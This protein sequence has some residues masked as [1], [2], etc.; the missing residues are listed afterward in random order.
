[1]KIYHLRLILSIALI[2]GATML[3]A[4]NDPLGGRDT[5]VLE[6]ERIEDVIDSEK[7][8]LKPPAQQ[9]QPPSL[10]DLEYLSR[11]FYVQ[12]VFKPRPPHLKPLEAER[13]PPL[14]N[15]MIR[16]GLGRYLTPLAQVYLNN[17]EDRYSNYGLNFTHF[18]SHSDE[19]SLREFREDYG[20]VYGSYQT[21]YN[22]F[23]GHVHLYNTGYF[24]YADPFAADTAATDGQI[25]DSLRMNFTR[26]ELAGNIQSLEDSEIPYYYDVGG[27]IRYYGGK[28]ENS[29]F[30][31]SLNPT[32]GISMTD[33]ISLNLNT[34]FTYIRG[35]I[36]GEKQNRTF[37]GLE[38]FLRFE[39]ETFSLKAGVQFNSFRNSVDT[40]GSQTVFGPAVEASFALIPESLDIIGGVSSGMKNNH[41]YDMIYENRFLDDDIDILPTIEKLHAYG[42]IRGNFSQLFDFT[43]K[44]YYKRW[45]NALMYTS[46]P[47]TG[48]FQATYDSLTTVVGVYAEV[49]TQFS[50]SLRGG[51]ALNINNFTTDSEEKF[52]HVAPLQLD[53]HATYTWNDQLSVNSELS[54]FGSTPMTLGET[55][56]VI[57]R[58]TFLLWNLGADYQITERFSVF[59]KLHNILNSKYQRWHNYRERPIDFMG[60][61]TII[62]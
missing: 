8:F 50:E 43:G 17:G 52:F 5:L 39:N 15:N 31:V 9:I 58:E 25:E 28:T 2:A 37:F 1:M 46:R 41:Y 45:E 13:R 16:L 27:A 44:V 26:V 62:F 47:G 23:G 51:A 48:Q 56:E 7:P 53:V 35:N 14:F 57:R 21:D 10:R 49:N 12:T 42:G 19:I 4:Q 38:P 36:V 11:D 18:S 40:T 34:D 29:E 22:K 24:H 20:T 55:N 6:N 59:L 60:G 32:G 33:Q 3:Q 61:I 30:H 54:V